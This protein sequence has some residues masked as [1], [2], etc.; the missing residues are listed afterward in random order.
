MSL[1]RKLDQRFDGILSSAKLFS[2]I[3]VVLYINHIVACLWFAVG[4]AEPMI[5]EDC[6]TGVDEN[7]TDVLSSAVEASPVPLVEPYR[8]VLC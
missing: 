6:V 4:N 1:I 8:L 2:L 5:F 3:A 7:G